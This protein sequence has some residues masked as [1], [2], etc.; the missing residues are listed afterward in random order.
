MKRISVI[1]PC[2]N[3]EKYIDRCFDSLQRQTLGM[4]QMELIF[5]DDASTDHTC[6]KLLSYEQS[7]PDSVIVIRFSENQKQ[8][9]A[10]NIALEYAS[11]AYVGYVDADD[12]VETNMFEKM[13]SAMETYDCDF[14]CCGWDYA[15]DPEHRKPTKN[16][17][18]KGYMNLE[19]PVV[20]TE[21][22]RSK[23]A[24]VAMWDKIFKK[25]FLLEHQIFCPEKILNEDIFFT[26]LVFVYAKSCYFIEEALYHYFVNEH[27]TMR[28]K[29][30]EY[31]FD[32]MTVTFGFLQTCIQRG[33]MEQNKEIIE[34]LFLERY[35]VYMLWEVFEQFPERA[36][37]VYLEMKETVYRWVPDYKLNSFR[38]MDGNEFDDMIL[39]LLDHEFNR[40]E[41]DQVRE[42]M[43]HKIKASDAQA[44]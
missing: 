38:K 7:F 1:I 8:G 35:Y 44:F 18:N 29:K 28:Q 36:Y 12:W 11:A 6:E 41:F 21:F 23:V 39:K 40:D 4:E 16:W 32:K 24:L 30:Q 33:L 31:Q 22:I 15:R 43:L 3:V 19:D 27:G 13:L 37:D 34:W 25:N 9:T 26:Y 20:R 5:V 2:F 17:G 10:R 42:Y 14:V